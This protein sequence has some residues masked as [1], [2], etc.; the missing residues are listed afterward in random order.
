MLAWLI[1]VSY[2]FEIEKSFK[3]LEKNNIFTLGTN[4]KYVYDNQFLLYVPNFCF[5]DPYVAKELKNQPL[6]K[7]DELINVI[8]SEI[9]QKNDF[10][11]KVKS[12]I[13][14]KE[15]KEA[16]YNMIKE[17]NTKYKTRLIYSGSEIKD[18]ETIYQHNVLELGKIQLIKNLIE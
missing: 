4:L 1:Q 6:D 16:Y 5:N 9:Y 2:I 18:N 7:Q 17:S 12:S 8:L 13:T 15:L 14:G 3:I 11:L 10:K